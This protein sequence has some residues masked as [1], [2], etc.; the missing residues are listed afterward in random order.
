MTSEKTDNRGAFTIVALPDTQMYS[1][2]YP[3]IFRAQT[4]WIVEQ[5]SRLNIHMVWHLGDV[6]RFGGEDERAWENAKQAMRLLDDAGIPC[7]IAI[8]N[9]DY[10][11]QLQVDRSASFFNRYFGIERYAG[12][13]WFGGA[14][15]PGRSENVYA[16]TEAGGERY[17]HLL[18]EFGP[19]KAVVEWA[20]AVVRAHADHRVFVVTHGYMHYHNG[21]TGP[22]DEWNPHSYPGAADDA[23]D[24]EEL[25]SAFVSRHPNIRWVHS[26]H[27][28]NGGQGLRT[29]AGVHGNLVHQVASNFQTYRNGGDGW[30]RLL[31][32]KPAQG[33]I[34]S[35]TY[36]PYRGEYFK[37][38]IGLHR[39][40]LPW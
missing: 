23:H 14:F 34:E 11:S 36:S 31:R 3:E 6:V 5:A 4:E 32:V 13:P 35:E 7:L 26:G 10:D 16:V 37:G 27:I 8:G 1:D 29:D 19:R 9:H 18:L 25:W 40:T 2:R 15:E 21:R 39:Y 20:D 12:R 24:G 30:L 38:E 17:L 28:L 33:V 22:G